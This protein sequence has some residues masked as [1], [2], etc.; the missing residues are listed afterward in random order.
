M[1][2]VLRAD[3]C[4]SA[5]FPIPT[6]GKDPRA[7]PTPYRVFHYFISLSS[8][9]QFI[10]IFSSPSSIIN[11]SS[12]ERLPHI[13]P[14]VLSNEERPKGNIGWWVLVSTNEWSS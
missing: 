10:Q 11:P 4:M 9:I 8:T 2:T 13:E 14:G 6:K 3:S 5:Y 12:A 1:Q 7:L